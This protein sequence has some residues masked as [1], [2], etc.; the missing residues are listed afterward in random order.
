LLA[1]S[2][3]ALVNPV[4]KLDTRSLADPIDNVLA[5]VQMLTL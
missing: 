3:Q 1:W 5:K 2:N 4:K